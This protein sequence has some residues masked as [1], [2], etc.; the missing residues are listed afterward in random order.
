MSTLWRSENKTGFFVLL[1]FCIV[2][3]L[4]MFYIT[5]LFQEI[6]WLLY[7]VNGIAIFGVLVFATILEVPIKV[8]KKINEFLK[9]KEISQP[10]PID[11]IKFLHGQVVSVSLGGQ[12]VNLCDYNDLSESALTR[13]YVIKP[14]GC[15]VVVEKNYSTL[16]FGPLVKAYR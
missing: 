7:L 10:L 15:V 9:I 13:V 3:V 1:G 16:I 8:E 6:K 11:D 2:L 12:T 14:L 4:S 5:P